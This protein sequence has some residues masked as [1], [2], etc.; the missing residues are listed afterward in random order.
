MKKIFSFFLTL[1]SAITSLA[2]VNVVG[3][4]R[5]TKGNPVEFLNV[6]LISESDTSTI[7]SGSVTD[8][9]GVYRLS[10]AQFGNYYIVAFQRT[11]C[12]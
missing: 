9:Q 11:G 10:N 7:V 12:G 5:D 1:L 3:L 6:V 4:V 8:L 2:Q